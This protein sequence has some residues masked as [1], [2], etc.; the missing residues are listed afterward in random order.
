MEH[1]GPSKGARPMK[2]D[3]PIRPMA[4]RVD[5]VGELPSAPCVAETRTL[6]L[7]R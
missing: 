5:S 2:G 4:N 6:S 1:L 7:C 3:F